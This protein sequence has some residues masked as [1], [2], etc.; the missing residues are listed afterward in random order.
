MLT[1]Y[2]GGLR[3]VH[4]IIIVYCAVMYLVMSEYIYDR[5]LYMY[6]YACTHVR[7][8]FSSPASE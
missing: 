2:S 6:E 8:L 5:V 7:M 1:T 3:L 4:N